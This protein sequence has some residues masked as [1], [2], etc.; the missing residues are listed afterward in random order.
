MTIRS[1]RSGLV[2]I[3]CFLLYA[4]QPDTQNQVPPLSATMTDLQGTVLI[5]KSGETNMQFASDQI[6]EEND[7]V[8]TGDDGRVRVDLSTGTI[9]RVA[10]SSLFTLLNNQ[11]GP[12]GVNTSIKLD[13]GNLWII[14]NGGSAE[15]ETPSGVASVRGSYLMV[16][17]LP[18]GGI[19][20]TCLEGDCR[21]KNESGE[22]F[23]TTGESAL[24]ENA[25]EAPVVE[26]MTDEEVIEWLENNPEA[27]IVIPS[28]TAT[29]QPSDTPLPTNTSAATSTP[30]PPP[31][32]TAVP[33]STSF[34]TAIPSNTRKVKP[35]ADPPDPATDTPVPPTNTPVTPPATPAGWG[36]TVSNVLVNGGNGTV[37]PGATFPVSFDY[38]IWN[39]ASCPSCIDQLVVGIDSTGQ[40]CAYDGIPPLY[41]GVAGSST[42]S[43]TAPVTPGIY[44]VV[45][46]QDLQF[47]CSN[48]VTANGGFGYQVIGTIVVAI[49]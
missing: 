38:S 45:L 15:V 47:S 48:A 41:P 13:A 5:K 14:L 40:Y 37:S 44:Q 16:A 30:V 24:V 10:P 6:L 26:R 43:L 21:I 25:Q 17:V 34:P 49:P 33:T 19:H 28:L 32:D 39:D 42:G 23:L 46:H 22:F 8:V 2:I 27:I 36:Y 31:S 12:D 9:I 4:C 3:C 11:A 1:I 35:P 7:Q 18:G 20:L 29:I